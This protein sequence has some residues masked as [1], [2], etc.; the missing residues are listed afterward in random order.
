MVQW[1]AVI[2]NDVKLQTNDAINN[3]VKLRIHD[4]INSDLKLQ[5]N[6][7]SIIMLNYKQMMLLIMMFYKQ[8]YD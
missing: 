3:Y 7:A 4:V 2:N 6:Y 1:N 8:S 5:T